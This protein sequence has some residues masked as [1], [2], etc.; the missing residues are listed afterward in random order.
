MKSV[1]KNSKWKNNTIS[2]FF[3]FSFF[4]L[5]LWLHQW[6][7]EVLRLGVESEPDLPAYATATAMPD[8][9]LICELHHSLWQCW[10]LNSLSKTR[11]RTCILTEISQV[12]Y[13]WATAG[14]PILLFLKSE[15]SNLK[16]MIGMKYYKGNSLL[17]Y[18]E[19][20]L[21]VHM[22]NKYLQSN[23]CYDMFLKCCKAGH[24]CRNNGYVFHRPI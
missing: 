16:N 2:S 19:A 22:L 24:C 1:L 15:E 5:F 6:H 8:L 23:I 11:D 4:L 17:H 7:M 12:R 20:S 10:I 3:F 21:N 18:T 9:S 13:H 14:T